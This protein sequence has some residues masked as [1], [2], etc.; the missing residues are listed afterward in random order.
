MIYPRTGGQAPAPPEVPSEI[1]KDFNE[2]CV[3]LNDS[4]QASGAL[5]RRCLQHVL[6]ER[7]VSTSDNL[8]RAIEDALASHL[9]SHIAHDLDAIR[10][11]GNF[12]AHPQKSVSTGAI[13]PVEPH[14]AEWNLHV[15]EMLF[16][17]Y[18]VQPAKSAAR[19]VALNKKLKEAGKPLMK[20]PDTGG[21]DTRQLGT[22]E[23]SANSGAAPD[24]ARS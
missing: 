24:V 19:R 12:A 14:E 1:A 2:A 17:F 4:A 3:V 16:D 23:G 7:G 13:L 8:N 10:N 21:D 5:S 9:P 11:I 18:Y 22:T 20:E 6:A 15:L